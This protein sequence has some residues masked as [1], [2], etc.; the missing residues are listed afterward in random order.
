[1]FFYDDVCSVFFAM[2]VECC[3]SGNEDVEGRVVDED[4]D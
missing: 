1:M 2:H 3:F 4:D